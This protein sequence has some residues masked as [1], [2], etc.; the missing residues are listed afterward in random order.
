MHLDG[1]PIGR[2]PFEFRLDRDTF[3]RHELRLS[4][5]GYESE[6][7]AC[8]GSARRGP[9]RR[10]FSSGFIRASS[11]QRQMLQDCPAYSSSEKRVGDAHRLDFTAARVEL[12]QGA[13][14]GDLV[15][16]PYRPEADVGTTEPVDLEGMHAFRR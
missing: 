2:T 13:A 8:R 9:K 4:A 12:L 11:R 15:F 14:A 16:E 6:T 7:V 3:D 1:E 5:E 10:H